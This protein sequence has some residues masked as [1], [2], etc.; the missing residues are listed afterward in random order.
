MTVQRD[1][2][3][4]LADDLYRR[5]LDAVGDQGGSVMKEVTFEIGAD[6]E[7]RAARALEKRG[8]AQ[9][10]GNKVTIGID[11]RPPWLRGRG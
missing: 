4:D 9:V 10:R 5:A 11:T 3:E 2:D 1:P 6:D 7:R 8:V